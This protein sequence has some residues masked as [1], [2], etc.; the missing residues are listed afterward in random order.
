MKAHY[1]HNGAAGL[2]KG[3]EALFN[4]PDVNFSANTQG[5]AAYNDPVVPIGVANDPAYA[6]SNPGLLND[7]GNGAGTYER[8]VRGIARET[9]EVLGSGA[10]LF[11]EMSF[12]SFT[13]DRTNATLISTSTIT[14]IVK[15][16]GV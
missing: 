8:G 14:V 11:N 13:S 9:A 16:T 6:A 10:T 5:P 4:E 3:R 7:D 12:S 15:K 2:R 1:Q